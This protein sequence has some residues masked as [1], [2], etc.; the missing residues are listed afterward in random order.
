MKLFVSYV[1]ILTNTHNK[2]LYTGVTN[3]LERRCFEHAKKVNRG[4]TSKYNIH[5]LVY[6]E[7]F[8][9]I[10]LAIKREKQ[11][12]SYSRTKKETLI[13]S[14]NPQWCDLCPNGKIQHP[15]H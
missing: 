3:D 15:A 11:I 4:F 7:S 12:K 14:F 8:E 9:D 13:N 10:E 6:Y 5:K 2:V 1:Y